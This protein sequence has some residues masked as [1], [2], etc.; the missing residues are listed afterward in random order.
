MCE[1][2]VCYDR[3][4]TCQFTCKHAFCYECTQKW[5]ENG[6]ESCPM[7]RRSMCFKGITQMKRIWDKQRKC[8]IL[9]DLVDEIFEDLCE[10]D[11][12]RFFMQCLCIIHER[13]NYIISKYPD[14]DSDT[15]EWAL[16]VTWFNVDYLMNAPKKCTYEYPTF[17]KYLLVSNTSYGVKNSRTLSRL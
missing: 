13:F 2:P 8:T 10:T 17:T 14:I 6:S 5:Y 4:A 11:D 1:C 12:M 16:R 7:C 3:E 9:A 15:F